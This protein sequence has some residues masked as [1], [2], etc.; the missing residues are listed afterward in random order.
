MKKLLGLFLLLITS[1]AYSQSP[2]GINY[3]AVARDA[4]GE[5][6]KN[7]TIKVQFTIL[8]G[9]NLSSAAAVYTEEHSSVSTNQYGLF[10]LVIGNGTPS[11][12]TDVLTTPS[13][14]SNNQF[15]KVEI[16]AGSGYDLVGETQLMSVPYA[17]YAQY[18][19]QGTPGATG[20]M[21]PAG[22]PGPTGPSGN[23]GAIGPTG[24]ASTVPGP[25]GPQGPTGANGAAGATGAQGPTGIA[26]TN[27]STG[28]TGPQGIPGPTGTPGP[29]GPPGLKGDTGVAGPT[30]PTGTF[31]PGNLAGETP[32]WNGTAWVINQN[33]YNNGGNVGIGTNTILPTSK[34]QLHE[35]SSNNNFLQ[36]TNAT[37]G[38]GIGSGFFFGIEN[39]NEGTILNEEASAIKF[40]IN[41]NE[42]MRLTPTG[43]VG[44]GTNS[45]AS[46]NLL[47]V[48]GKTFTDSIQIAKGAATG[49]ILTSDATGNASWSNAN[50][51]GQ[52]GI[53]GLDIYKKNVG[54][55]GVGTN[56][57]IQLLTLSSGTNTV[58]RMERTNISAFDWEQVADNFGF[59]IRGGADGANAALTDFFNIKGNG[60]IGIGTNQQVVALEI[61]GSESS[62]VINGNGSSPKTALRIHNIDQSTNN[63]FSS[64]AFSTVLSNNGV[65]EMA[66]IVGQNVNHTV[67]S[68]QGDLVFLTNFSTGGLQEKMR[69]T[70]NGNV[71][72]GLSNPEN[73]KLHIQKPNTSGVSIFKLG[74]TNQPTAEWIFDVDGASV[75]T[76]TN[77]NN[78][79]PQIALSANNLGNVGVGTT[80]P[81]SKLHVNGAVTY[82]PSSRNFAGATGSLNIGDEGYIR[83]LH[84]NTLTI[85]SF[86]AGSSIGQVVIIENA[87]TPIM[88]INNGSGVKLNGNTAFSMGQNST[89][90]LIWN[91]NIWIEIGRSL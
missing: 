58:L 71:G 73:S 20:P 16:D 60:D 41:A 13:W 72:I 3:Q 17:L 15:L 89:L 86:G 38:T 78:G 91:G 75:F 12:G 35:A 23:N 27:G 57:P 61:D 28:P 19:G 11:I 48:K 82:S 76:L 42:V 79:T 84:S 62:T 53:S 80:T 85:T 46:G 67:G 37:T 81:T 18:G 66:K 2:A 64:I 47:H 52:W 1:I 50:S 70:G 83:I 43:Q 56:S 26:G 10:T 88:T 55:V 24:A 44:I 8:Q 6:L 5:L 7:Q 33:I 63:N 21:G 36:V 45:P 74:N 59:T 39:F 69:I 40:R 49:A 90:S 4:N 77:E 30:G 22:V 32:Y 65:S 68:N 87:S 14:G 25:T 29:T 31:M 51:I 9:A 34:L 54:N